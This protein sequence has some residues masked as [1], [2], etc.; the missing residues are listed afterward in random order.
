MSDVFS[1]DRPVDRPVKV[2]IEGGLVLVTL[3]DGRVIGNP[4]AWHPWLAHATPEQ[5]AKV[6]LHAYSVDWTELDEGLDIQG[7][8]MG[9][10]PKSPEQAATS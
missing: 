2:E 5:Q 7:M 9:I 4:L 1:Y 6:E 8:L 3:A 10:R